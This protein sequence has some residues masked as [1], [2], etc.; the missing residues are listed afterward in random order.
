MFSSLQGLKPSACPRPH[1]RLD[2]PRSVWPLRQQARPVR[3]P[4]HFLTAST[5]LGSATNSSSERPRRLTWPP[6][7]TPHTDP[8]KPL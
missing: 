8:E 3:P 7:G 6:R 4:K 1:T 2:F 5:P